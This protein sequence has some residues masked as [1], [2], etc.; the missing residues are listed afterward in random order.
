MPTEGISAIRTDLRTHEGYFS[1]QHLMSV[2]YN[3][4]GMCLLCRTN[5]KFKYSLI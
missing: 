2:S 5:F 1:T 3:R 4:Q